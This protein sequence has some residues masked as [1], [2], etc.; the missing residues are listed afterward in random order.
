MLP[1]RQPPQ[2]LTLLSICHL[3]VAMQILVVLGI[4]AGADGLR[5]W[6]F[7]SAAERVMFRLRTR[8]FAALLRQEV[9]LLLLLLLG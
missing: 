9:G 3:A 8:L 4:S 5:S 1:H 6:L 7:Q 2:T